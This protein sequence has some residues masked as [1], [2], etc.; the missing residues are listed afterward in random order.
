MIE[1]I[2]QKIDVEIVYALLSGKVTNAINRTLSRKLKDAG[3]DI[4]PAQVSILYTLWHAD[5]I[6]Q[7]QLSDY[8]AKDKPSITRLLDNMDKLQ[9][10]KRQQDK[11]D[12]RMNKIYLTPKA[13][14]IK[15]QVREATVNALQD[16]FKGLTGNDMAEVQRM[17]KIIFNNL[18][19]NT[20]NDESED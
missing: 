5:G 6:T 4:S 11:K 9:L 12:R 20:E 18:G 15:S 14:S 17:M 16:G 8:T 13:Q 19:G 7:K 1:N 2:E 3:I 10:I